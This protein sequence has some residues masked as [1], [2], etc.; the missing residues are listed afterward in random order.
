MVAHRYGTGELT[1]EM[2]SGGYKV[3]RISTFLQQL[4]AQT[5][6]RDWQWDAHRLIACLLYYMDHGDLAVS[7]HAANESTGCQHYLRVS[8]ASLALLPKRNRQYLPLLIFMEFFCY[9]GWERME[10][11]IEEYFGVY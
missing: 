2:T 4:C 10:Q 5:S 7:M 9:W 8:E 3:N 6:R 11:K 1:L